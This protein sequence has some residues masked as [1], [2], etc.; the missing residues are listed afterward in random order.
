MEFVQVPKGQFMMG[1][2]A[3]DTE[4]I[5]SELPAHKV[6]ISKPF[7]IGKYEVTQ[8]QWEAVMGSNPSVFFGE[9]RPVDNVSWNDVQEFIAKLN[10]NKDG[11]HY[12]LPTEAEW[13]YAARAGA[14]DVDPMA[15][16]ADAWTHENSGGVTHAVGLL[17]PNAWGIYDMLGNV[18]EWVQDSF[19]EGYYK[20]SPAVDPQG[21]EGGTS[22][23]RGGSWRYDG[24]YS[25]VSER[26]FARR[27]IKSETNG[28]RCARDVA[29]RAH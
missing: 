9:E 16:V 26:D 15:A 20:S 8:A 18:A 28:F 12:R 24:G 6:T 4:C 5:S 25:R 17:K 29:S 19:G 13:E 23:L 27:T 22:V 1:C 3:S 10:A 21:P 2:S 7:E 11:Y 14:N